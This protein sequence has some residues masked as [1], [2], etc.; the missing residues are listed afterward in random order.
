MTIYELYY[1]TKDG[2]IVLCGELTSLDEVEQE[3]NMLSI[4][5]PNNQYFWEATYEDEQ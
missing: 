4:E 1:E 5:F 3:K 2:T